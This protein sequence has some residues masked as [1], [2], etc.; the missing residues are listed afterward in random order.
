MV[1]R[2]LNPTKNN[3]FSQAINTLLDMGINYTE[4]GYRAGGWCI[5]PFNSL[6]EVF[7]KNNILYDFSV[8]PGFKNSSETQFFDYS[9]NAHLNPYYFFN[10]ESEQNDH[11]SFIEF[12]ISTIALSK[13]AIFADKLMKKYLWKIGDK[14]FGD[15][16]SAKTAGAKTNFLNTEMISLD[17]L[18]M[19]KNTL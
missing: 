5:Q 17:I 12:P 6:I 19:S 10:N 13:T 14:G 8:L 1:D 16:V 18:N 4:W 3:L 7:K 9:D 2:I 15:G 11:G